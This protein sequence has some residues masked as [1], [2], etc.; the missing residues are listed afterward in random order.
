MGFLNGQSIVVV[1]IGG[2][3]V[4]MF[5]FV[6]AK[7]VD[8]IN[9]NINIDTHTNLQWWRKNGDA[10]GTLHLRVTKPIPAGTELDIDIANNQLSE[11]P[12]KRKEREDA[13]ITATEDRNRGGI[14]TYDFPFDLGTWGGY[15]P[16]ARGN[17]PETSTFQVGIRIAPIRV[18]FD[19]TAPDFLISKDHA[20]IGISLYPPPDLVGDFWTHWGIGGGHLWP[21]DGSSTSNVFYLSFSTKTP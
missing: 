6:M 11:S 20:G 5:F 21:I 10:A 17:S 4:M 2:I 7:P 14:T 18:L 15:A 16:D 13:G 3:V 19:T 9:G 1:I 12:K 8:S